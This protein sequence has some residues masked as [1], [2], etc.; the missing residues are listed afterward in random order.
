MWKGDPLQADPIGPKP[1]L[2]MRMAIK[3]EVGW[4][5]LGD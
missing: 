3:S 1:D 4:I 5:K 2:K